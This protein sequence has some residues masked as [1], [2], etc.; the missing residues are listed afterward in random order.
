MY[1]YL[2]ECYLSFHHEGNDWRALLPQQGQ[3]MQVAGGG[4]Q[5]TK[6]GAVC[7]NKG[8]L[9]KCHITQRLRWSAEKNMHDTG[10]GNTTV[11]TAPAASKQASEPMRCHIDRLQHIDLANFNVLRVR[12][13]SFRKNEVD[14]RNITRDVFACL[15]HRS[16][17]P[18]AFRRRQQHRQQ[19][20]RRAAFR[21]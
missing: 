12:P 3:R 5:E 20:E 9:R 6:I 8:R 16:T 7:T 18:S 19:E 13:E 10:K 11:P 14:S 1:A 21:Q 17:A 15:H 4:E 2:L